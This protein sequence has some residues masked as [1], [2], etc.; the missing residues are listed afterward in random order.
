MGGQVVHVLASAL[1][2]AQRATGRATL[3]IR[4]VR[5]LPPL[6]SDGSR[7]LVVRLPSADGKAAALGLIE[8]A[9]DAPMARVEARFCGPNGE[10]PS[11]FVS[12]ISGEQGRA[13]PPLVERASHDDLCLRFGELTR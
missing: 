1:A 5:T 6:L 8:F 10:G 13:A 3:R 2:A 12:G 11:L 4:E 9:S 7:E